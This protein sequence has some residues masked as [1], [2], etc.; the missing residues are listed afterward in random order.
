[1]NKFIELVV[2]ANKF[3]DLDAYKAHL[4]QQLR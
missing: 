4:Y 2:N 3:K 1:M